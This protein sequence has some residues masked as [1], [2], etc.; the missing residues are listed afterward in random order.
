MFVS[1]IDYTNPREIKD[2]TDRLRAYSVVISVKEELMPLVKTKEQAVVFVRMAEED[3]FAVRIRGLDE[4]VYRERTVRETAVDLRNGIGVLRAVEMEGRTGGDADRVGHPTELEVI[5]LVEVV[6]GDRFVEPQ[7]EVIAH[8]EDSVHRFGFSEDAR[9][10]GVLHTGND[11]RGLG[12][13]PCTVSAEG[14]GTQVVFLLHGIFLTVETEGSNTSVFNH[15]FV[16]RCSVVE[17]VGSIERTEVHPHLIA[18]RGEFVLELN[19]VEIILGDVKF[20]DFNRQIIA[21]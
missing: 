13:K 18:L 21:C 10:T 1:V 7:L 17:R 9:R 15:G 11:R 6:T 8:T 20:S 16:A 12:D 5:I 14:D 3:G 2:R 4:H 19:M